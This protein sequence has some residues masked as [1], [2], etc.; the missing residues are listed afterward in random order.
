MDQRSLKVEYDREHTTD[1]SAR[2]RH[3]IRNKLS[4]I[5]DGAKP[6]EIIYF[7]NEKTGERFY[8]RKK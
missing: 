4:L 1:A 2:V 7:V 5:A 3:E 6:S 8:A